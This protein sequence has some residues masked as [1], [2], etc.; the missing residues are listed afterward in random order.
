[1]SSTST[2]NFSCSS[3]TKL[4]LERTGDIA[5]DTTNSPEEALEK[6]VSGRYDAIVSDY[7]MPGM[8]GIMLLERIRSGGSDIPFIIFTGRGRE[9]VAIRALNAGADFYLQKGGDPK[10]QFAEL[11]NAIRQA[12]GRRRAEVA[13]REREAVPVQDAGSCQP[14]QLELDLETGRLIWSDETY[15]IFGLDPQEFPAT[16]EAFLDTVH[17]DDRAFVDAAYSGSIADGKD[18]CEIEH[19]LVRGSAGEIRYV[20]EKCEHQRGESGR[21]IRSLGMVHDITDRKRAEIE[22]QRKHAEL[23]AA[24]EDLTAIGE[25]L[26]SSFDALAANQQRLRE[27]EE[28]YR[29]ISDSISD[30]A[31]SCLRKDTGEYALDWL[32][33]AVHEITGYTTDEILAEGCWKCIVYPE[34]LP[35]FEREV[36]SL[37]PGDSSA[38]ELRIVRP[39][40][41]ARWLHISTS[42]T[43][44]GNA[45][46]LHGGWQD[47]TGRKD[48]EEALRESEKK[49]PGY[50]PAKFRHDLHLLPPGGDYL[51][52]P[53]GGADPGL[54]A[55]GGGR[56][57]LQG[58]CRPREQAGLGEG[59]PD[60]RRRHPGR[61]CPDQV[62]P[63]G[64]DICACRGS[65]ESPIF[66]DGTVVGVQAVGRDI[67]ARKKAE[68]AL[69][70]R[71]HLLNKV[72]EI[73]PIGVWLADREGR[74][75]MGN[76]AGKRIWGAEPL[77]APEEYGVFRARRLPSGKEVAADDWAL[78]HT[79]ERGATVAD[80]LLEIDALDGKKR[81]ILNYTS[82][83]LDEDGGIAGAVIVNQEIT[84]H[85]LAEKA[86]RESAEKMESIFRAAPAGIGVAVD[87]IFTEVNLG[88][89]ELV[90]YARDELV[91][92]SVRLVYPSDDD[93]GLIGEMK[94]SQIE[95]DGASRVETRFRRK[96][97][98][99]ID[100]LLCSTP[101][102]PSDL[103]RGVTFTVLDITERRVM[104]LEIAF[105]A[106][107]LARYSN[108]LAMAN[109]KLNLMSSITR[110]DVLNQL[111]VLQGNLAFAEESVPGGDV[112]G[113]LAKVRDAARRIQRQIEFTRDYTETRCPVA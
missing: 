81:V 7:Q 47:I 102:D 35:L 24:Y 40:G 92:R 85:W 95:R 80:E 11:A 8:D 13:V 53:G 19:R 48:A 59:L 52:H 16:Y 34:D 90:G 41:S 83:V 93:F 26:R 105:H 2:T 5:V 70:E 72:F 61:G 55:G 17:P 82:P 94:S 104:E 79:I 69:R 88:F 111:M 64:R 21:V 68:D 91:G 98:S 109:R 113:Y 106:E 10:A 71:E 6:V 30:V 73:L 18:S 108:S 110:H 66:R 96:D 12:V 75:V 22:L 14:R 65:N 54:H 20:H 62:P 99:L 44:D 89:C 84:D 86:L 103:S 29:R 67:T 78:V 58:L 107:E 56:H 23:V 43:G 15:R 32:A 3:L 1:M 36:L 50:H 4:F 77:V 76:P 45:T 112:S 42:C 38:C 101:L 25:E 63:K 51:H 97:G 49:D 37:S 57:R 33:G 100:V 60:D 46:R 39:D 31:F 87:R 27:N 28:R 9:E 74:L